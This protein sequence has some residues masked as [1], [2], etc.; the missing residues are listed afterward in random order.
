MNCPHH[1]MIYKSKP[2]SY[3]DLP[4]RL[5]EFIT[6]Y[7]IY[8]SVHSSCMSR[9]RGFT[10]D[11]AYIFCTEAQV[12]EEFRNCIDFA[13]TVLRALGLDQYRVRLGFRDPSSNKYVGSPE[14]WDKAEAAIERVAREMD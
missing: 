9:V 3:R 10:Q 7:R 14:S 12:A 11:D 1:I 2:R 6:V 5:A 8:M 4:L 13:Q